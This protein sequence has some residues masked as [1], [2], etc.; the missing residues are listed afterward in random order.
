M[1]AITISIF[2]HHFQDL[3]PRTCGYN[4]SNME[5]RMNVRK[6]P[7]TSLHWVESGCGY[8]EKNGKTYEVNAGEIFIIC[9]NEIVKYYSNNETPW[10]YRWISFG[11]E[12]AS[13]FESLPTV[14]PYNGD[15]FIRMNETKDMSKS[16]EYKLLSLLYELYCDISVDSP[17]KPIDYV[18]EAREFIEQN[19]MHEINV[20]SIAKAININRRYLSRIFK[21]KIGKTLSAYL[22]TIR[23]QSAWN[24]LCCGMNVTETAFACGFS[25]P[26]IFSKKFKQYMGIS[27]SEYIHRIL[28]NKDKDVKGNTPK[29]KNI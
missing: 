14:V 2:N 12:L 4:L 13:L 29:L 25:N 6:F 9:K 19:Y 10:N 21:E 17:K 11:G 16:R 15:A 22:T 24:C 26:Q 18:Y 3:N 8:L 7:Y 20:E 28:K 5:R 1:K 27:P 23:I